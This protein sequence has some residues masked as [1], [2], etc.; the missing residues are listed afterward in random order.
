MA[1]SMIDLHCHILP[2][3]DD[4]AKTFED[5]LEMARKAVEQ[6]ITHILC[7]PHH[8]NGV[9]NNP[10]SKVRPLVNELQENLDSNDLPIKVLSG[11]EIRFNGNLLEEISQKEILF[12]DPSNVYLLIEFPTNSIP[13]HVEEIF[14]KLRSAGHVPVIVHPE[15]NSRFREDPNLL[16]P[17]LKM[18]YLAQL[19][20]P[21]Y[22]GV[23]GK[24]IQKIA[25]VMIQHNFIHL[26]AS[27]AHRLQNRDF[28]L[29]EAFEKVEKDFGIEKAESLKQA[30]RDV[31]AGD[32]LDLET[33]LEIPSKNRGFCFFKKFRS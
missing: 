10:A 19:T 17:F 11:Q 21:S 30:A 33:P 5:S 6:G 4:G 24:S 1:S 9:Y 28:Y 12:V 29:K 15:R 23:F 14:F 16:L 20:A 8:G 32:F 22:V 25:K 26:I 3:V 7:T 13:L 2:G 31:V 18:G 27:D